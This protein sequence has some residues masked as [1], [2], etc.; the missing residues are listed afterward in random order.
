VATDVPVY[1]GPGEPNDRNC[2]EAKQGQIVC[3]NSD[4]AGLMVRAGDMNGPTS[5]KRRRTKGLPC[6]NRGTAHHATQS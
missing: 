2:K 1:D 5:S 3:H 4:H 6:A